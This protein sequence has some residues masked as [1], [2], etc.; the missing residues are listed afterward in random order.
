MIVHAGEKAT[1]VISSCSLCNTL[2]F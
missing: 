2:Y 1:L